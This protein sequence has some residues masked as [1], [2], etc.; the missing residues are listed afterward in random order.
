MR[1]A[2]YLISQSV[3][4]RNKQVSFVSGY[5]RDNLGAYDLLFVAC[6][7][8]SISAALTWL[9]MLA[10]KS[11][12]KRKNRWTLEHGFAITDFSPGKYSPVIARSHSRDDHQTVDYNLCAR[13]SS[14]AFY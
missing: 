2:H 10:A 8:L 14:V 9:A 12:R 6:G 5:F 11:N 1:E 7:C 13:H 3:R 4:K